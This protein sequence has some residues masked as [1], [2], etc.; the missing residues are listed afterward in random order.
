MTNYAYVGRNAA[1]GLDYYDLSGQGHEIKAKR[2]AGVIDV[3]GFGDLF[4]RTL[5]GIQKSSIEVK[6]HWAP[7]YRL[8]A[9]ISQRFGQDSDVLGFYGP[10]GFSVGDAI[11]LQPSVI[12]KYE[13]DGKIKGAIDFDMVMHARGAVDDGYVLVSPEVFTTATGAS[14]GAGILDNTATGGATAA[15]GAG[16]IHVFSATG[17]T[18]SI[19]G[20]IQHSV[21]GVTYADLITFDALT[22]AGA[23]RVELPKQTTVNPF[24][25]ASYTISGTTPKFL[26]MF[27]FARGVVRI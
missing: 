19:T 15:G 21:D 26:V 24:V 1:W 11:V 10:Q 2:D 13:R 8:D 27:A 17:T 20:K 6:G 12:T 5:A 18:P 23:Q 3:T 22:A 25:K 16:Q 14:T 4:E 9:V 7:G